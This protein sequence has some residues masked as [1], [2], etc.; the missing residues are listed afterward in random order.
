[1]M[2][3]RQWHVLAIAAIV[4]LLVAV[5]AVHSQLDCDAVSDDEAYVPGALVGDGQWGAADLPAIGDVDQALAELDSSEGA[6]V[7]AVDLDGDRKPE[8]FVASREIVCGTGGC[9][10]VLLAAP[11][12]KRIGTF[13]GH[14]AILDERINGYRVIQTYSRYRF[15]AT[16]LD[17]HVFDGKA[18]RRVS[19]A[20]LEPCGFAAWSRRLRK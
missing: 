16:A 17:T 15:E 18:Y 8:S 11:S 13:F 7:Y 14:L 19:H 3:T 1:M 6:R 5:P 10:F 12:M 9:P 20:V 4:Q 2:R